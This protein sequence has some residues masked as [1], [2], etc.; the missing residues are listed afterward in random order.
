M[1]CSTN[2]PDDRPFL[3]DPTLLAFGVR[4]SWLHHGPAMRIPMKLPGQS[5]MMARGIPR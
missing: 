1:L 5:G 4:E 2:E 3:V